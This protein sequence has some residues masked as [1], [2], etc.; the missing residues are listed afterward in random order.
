MQQKAIPS[1]NVRTLAIILDDNDFGNTFRP[2]LETIYRAYDWNGG[3][4]KEVLETAVRSGIEFHYRVFQHGKTFGDKGYGAV[5]VTMQYLSSK[6]KVL[7]DEDA[8]ADICQAHHD[9]G[10]W[11]LELTTGNVFAY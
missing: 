4:S 7:F 10:A 1:P 8:E 3:L 6:V 2:L 11:Y 9:G 5:E